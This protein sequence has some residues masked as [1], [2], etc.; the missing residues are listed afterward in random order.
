MIEVKHRVYVWEEGN[1]CIKGRYEDVIK[2]EEEEEVIWSQEEERQ[3]LTICLVSF[4]FVLQVC[5]D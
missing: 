2:D 3:T 1:W 5:R 4:Y